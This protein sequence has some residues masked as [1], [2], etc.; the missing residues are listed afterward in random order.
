MFKYTVSL[1]ALLVLFV[2]A[3]A[4]IDYIVQSSTTH[5][6]IYHAKV[7]DIGEDYQV[8]GHVIAQAGEGISIKNLEKQ[9][10]AKAREKGADGIVIHG[11]RIDTGPIIVYD[12]ETKTIWRTGPTIGYDE[13]TKTVWIKEAQITTAITTTDSEEER[14]IKAIFIKYKKNL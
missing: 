11:Y 14:Q 4:K 1:L 9:F 10:L 12:E 6:D 8:I 7:D 3:C 5:L 2:A 13:E